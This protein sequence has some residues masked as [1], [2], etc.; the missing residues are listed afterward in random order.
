MNITFNKIIDDVLW[1]VRYPNDEQDRQHTLNELIKLEQV[2]NFL[3]EN[4][5]IDLD[6]FKD[7][8]E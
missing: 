8:L 3:L 7:F 6:S 1:A 5:I 4:Q 2:R